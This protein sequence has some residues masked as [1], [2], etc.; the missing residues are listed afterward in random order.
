MFGFSFNIFK[1]N[2]AAREFEALERLQRHLILLLPES[3]EASQTI[4]PLPAH[5]DWRYAQAA[6]ISVIRLQRCV[7]RCMKIA[8][9]SKPEL[10]NLLTALN[11]YL[12]KPATERSQEEELKFRTEISKIAPKIIRLW[13]QHHDF[14]PDKFWDHYFRTH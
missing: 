3:L 2:I 7:A 1:K 10:T 14:K 9:K 5:I 11:T 12:K 8:P 4:H 13:V 6:S